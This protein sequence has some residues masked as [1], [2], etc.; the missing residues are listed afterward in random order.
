V[1]GG[2]HHE[3]NDDAAI[4]RVRVREVVGR[5]WAA[6]FEGLSICDAEVGVTVIEGP[7]ADQAALHGLLN[8][9]R[10]LGLTLLSVDRIDH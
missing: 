8:R 3:M 9:V 1:K 6:W 7:I 10:D 4:Y 5:R 2:E